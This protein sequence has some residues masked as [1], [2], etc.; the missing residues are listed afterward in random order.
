MNVV[1][2][3]DVYVGGNVQRLSHDL[4]SCKLAMSQQ[5]ARGRHG[6][7]AA[8]SDSQDAVR[9]L[10]HV[11]R[12]AD[13]QRMFDVDDGEQRL[14]PPQRSV[15]TPFLGQFGRGA[16]H[17]ARI[18]LQFRLKTFQQGERVSS[19]TGKT[20]QHPSIEQRPN[21]A[22]ISFHDGGVERDLTI[23][24]DRHLALVAHAE[25][26]GRSYFHRDLS[27]VGDGTIA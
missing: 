1:I 7:I 14:Q 10:N 16:G 8:R 27:R 21:L 17:I 12:P 3:I 11:T 6:K 4:G 23:T 20:A 18:V 22:R 19:S 9:R 24:S 5:S 13:E 15:S 2:R 25:Y 26:R